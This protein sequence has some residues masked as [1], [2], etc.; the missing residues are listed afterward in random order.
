MD[1]ER[2]AVLE[3]GKP[4][5]GLSE[6]AKTVSEVALELK[7]L[8][9]TLLRLKNQAVYHTDAKLP[10]GTEKAPADLWFQPEGE[11]FLVSVFHD[12]R[13]NRYLMP[14]NHGVDKARELTLRF[15]EK[16]VIELLDRKTGK[17]RRV[18]VEDKGEERVVKMTLAAGDG[19]LLRVGSER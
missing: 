18:E 17:W 19:A 14:V 15:R 11:S 16:L 5:F 10:M 4:V 3:C 6:P 12:E 13:R 1:K 9:P 8:G 2:N 7:A